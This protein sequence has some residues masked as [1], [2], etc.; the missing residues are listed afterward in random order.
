MSE[1]LR[2][3]D[4]S[5]NLTGAEGN[6]AAVQGLSFSLLRERRVALIGESGSGKSLTALAILGLLPRSRFRVT[7]RVLL[8]DIDLMKLSDS[9]LNEIR[10]NRVAMTFQESGA[11]M[12][13]ASSVG[14]LISESLGAHLKLSRTATRQKAEQMLALV[15]IA[16]PRDVF[17]SY[18]HELSGGMRQRVSLATA[19]SC[20]PD[21]LIADQP[22]SGL[23]PTT[24]AQIFDLLGRV[25]AETK[26]S[27]LMITH[28]FGVVSENA[29]EV[30]VMYAG[31]VVEHGPVTQVLDAPLHPYT[32]ALLS[33]IPPTVLSGDPENR[34]L[35]MLVQRQVDNSLGCRFRSRCSLRSSLEDAERC[36]REPPDLRRVGG[37]HLSRCHFSE[38]LNG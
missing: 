38:R 29:D 35:P 31:E 33:S 11:A 12:N 30:L 28:S 6:S 37:R 3:D 17:S 20:S 32:A 26:M 14:C 21:V 1:L 5:I 8:E 34:R 25:Q 9:A 27:I 22:T 23:D 2:V 7:G 16:K 24:Q 19:L 4:L 18:P 10:G 36:D 15:G 13:P